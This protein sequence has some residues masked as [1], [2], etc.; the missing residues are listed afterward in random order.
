MSTVRRHRAGQVLGLA[1]LLAGL[2]RPVL[3]DG[4]PVELRSELLASA[5]DWSDKGRTDI[6]RQK[7]AKLLAVEPDSPEGLAFLGDLALRESKLDEARKVLD[8]MQAWLPQHAATRALEQAYQVYSQQREKLA[9]M[10]LMVRAGRKADAATLAR[11]LFPAGAPRYGALGREI[12]LIT[13]Q[14]TLSDALPARAPAAAQ[15]RTASPTRLAAAAVAP[16]GAVTRKPVTDRA[17]RSTATLPT[18][19]A[20]ATSAVS[21]TMAP[22][23]ADDANK[24]PLAQALA[25]AQPA[26]PSPGAAPA[27]ASLAAARAESL[28]AQAEVERK[29]ERLSPA[30][31]LLEEALQ[32]TPDEPWL[33]YDLARLYVRLQLPE[34]ARSVADEGLARLPADTD[35]RFAHALLLAA[36]DDNAAAWADLQHIPEAERSSGMQ[37][38]EKRLT[39]SLRAQETDTLLATARQQRSS[40]HYGEALALFQQAQQAIGAGTLAGEPADASA[41]DKLARDIQEIEARRQAWVEVGQQTLEKNST[42]GLGSLRGWER[43]VVAWLPWGYDGTLF[44]HA[45]Q[46][47]LDAGSYAGGDPFTQPGTE[48]ILRGLPQRADGFNA[49]VGYVGE[50]VRWDLGEI[51]LGFAVRNWVGGLRYGGDVGRVGYSV[52]LAR[53]PLTGTLLSYAG[54]QDPQT[55]EVWGGVVATGAGGRLSTDIG[56]FSTSV[57]ASAASLSGRN[58]A[59][60]TRLQWRLAADRDVYQDALQVLNIGLALSGLQHERDLSGYTWGHGGYY[61]PVHNTTLSLPL[62]WSGRNGPL[63]WLLRASV[64]VSSSTSSA[65]DYYPTNATLQQATGDV[66]AASSSTGSGWAMSGAAEYQVNAH[67]SLGGRLEREVSDYYTPLSLLFYARYAFDPVRQPLARRPLPV[68]AYSQF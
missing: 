49:G 19:T 16:G 12:A 66:Y 61:S 5:Q 62:E 63:T 47:Q 7:I 40:G 43:P 29:A 32:Q 18:A 1:C 13:G 65:T 53:R 14:R 28:R 2:A 36:L 48:A 15:A 45:D 67:L 22:Q 46:V 58:V 23:T 3:A 56:P 54:T 37:S 39:S 64:S 35:M 33:R 52:E 31:R 38:L 57:S 60:N 44:V 9:R 55:G 34:Q 17:A 21:A 8:T 50:A 42:E 30:L 41:Q 6:A 26:Q 10:R 25:P 27:E 59:D 24:Q 4:A 68:K 20:T 11:E 51:G